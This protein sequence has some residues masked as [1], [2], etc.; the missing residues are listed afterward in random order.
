MQINLDVP[1]INTSA[2]GLAKRHGLSEVFGCARMYYG[3][4][5]NIDW[6]KIFGITTFELG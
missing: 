4:A 2:M 5:P 3:E 6:N 1:E